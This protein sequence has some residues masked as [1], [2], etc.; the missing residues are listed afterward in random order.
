MSKFKALGPEPDVESAQKMF[1]HNCYL[2]GSDNILI[3]AD[4][5]QNE[6]SLKII[7]I[8]SVFLYEEPLTSSEGSLIFT[9]K[10]N[11]L[12]SL[13]LGQKIVRI[14]MK[15]RQG[16]ESGYYFYLFQCFTCSEHILS[17]GAS[18]ILL[19]NNKVLIN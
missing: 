14:S 8:S 16:A 17:L 5:F 10:I 4:H 19:S 6:L 18:Y 7:A 11:P 15:T 2:Y 3:Q 9:Q 13:K 1:G 12:S